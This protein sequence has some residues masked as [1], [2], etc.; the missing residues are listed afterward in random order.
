MGKEGG[1]ERDREME[2]E[3]T[4]VHAQTKVCCPHNIPVRNW[5]CKSTN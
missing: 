4:R 1:T 3:I 5:K 2:R